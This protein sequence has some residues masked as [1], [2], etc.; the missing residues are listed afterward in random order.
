[1]FGS[2]TGNSVQDYYLAIEK[3]VKASGFNYSQYPKQNITECDLCLS[4]SSEWTLYAHR[5][6]YCLPVRSMICKKCGLV[7]ITPRM[8]AI[9]YATFYEKWYR[10]LVDAFNGREASDE[11]M[12]QVMEAQAKDAVRFLSEHMPSDFQIKTMLDIGGSIG[13]FAKM[14]CDVTGAS[15]HVIDP[16]K[17]EVQEAAKKGLTVSCNN[18]EF[19]STSKT[20]D[21]ISMLRTVEHLDTI[22]GAFKKVKKLL[23]PGGL[24]LLDIVNHKFIVD[25]VKD[26]CFATKLDHVY[27]LTSK[28]IGQYLDNGGFEIVA[29]SELD[30]RYIMYLVRYNG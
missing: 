4:P 16:N 28:T 18:F 20:F 19:Y 7:F 6:R 21:L 24:F 10:K 13:S 29:N 15:G 12:V 11:Y 3:R 9:Q 26:K 2:T 22:R 17:K 14:V 5:D 30:Q 23:N 25:M 8:D 27:Q 1:M